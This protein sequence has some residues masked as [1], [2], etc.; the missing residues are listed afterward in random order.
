MLTKIKFKLSSSE[1]PGVFLVFELVMSH[2]SRY[3]ADTVF[4]G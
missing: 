2:P 3:P 1:N 4:E